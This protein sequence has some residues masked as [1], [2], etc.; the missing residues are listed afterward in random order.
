VAAIGHGAPSALSVYDIPQSRIRMLCSLPKLCRLRI[1]DHV[2]PPPPRCLN[3]IENP[4]AL[5]NARLVI[6]LPLH[7]SL[8]DAVLCSMPTLCSSETCFALGPCSENSN[9]RNLNDN[10]HLVPPHVT[11]ASCAIRTSV[12][13]KCWQRLL[14]RPRRPRQPPRRS[15]EAIPVV[16]TSSCLL[17]IYLN[18]PRIVVHWGLFQQRISRATAC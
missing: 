18:V 4:S 8:R 9:C 1:E 6:L 17:S 2:P 5:D 13:L 14:E 11:I 16:C 10:Q 3:Q 12:P 7:F 15:R